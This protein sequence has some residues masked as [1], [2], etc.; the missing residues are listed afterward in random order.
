MQLPQDAL[1]HAFVGKM[2]DEF[3]TSKHRAK[4]G[5]KRAKAEAADAADDGKKVE[6]IVDV[7][8]T[9]AQRSSTTASG[10]SPAPSR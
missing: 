4:Q 6:M 5:R 8:D 2:A 9:V 10:T 1:S 3:A 7:N